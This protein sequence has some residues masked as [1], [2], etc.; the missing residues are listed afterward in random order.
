MGSSVQL[1]CANSSSAL[2]NQQ[3]T[4]MFTKDKLN[5]LFIDNTPNKYFI[6][7][8]SSLTVTNL[9][10][11]DDGYYACTITQPNFTTISSYQLY[12]KGKLN[13]LKLLMFNHSFF[14]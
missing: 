14:L 13:S 9:Q 3:V 8:D 2:G 10:L 6:D 7:Y 11:N 12:V 5:Y 1:I 4:W